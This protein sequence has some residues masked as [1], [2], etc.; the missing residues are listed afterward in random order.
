MRIV[1]LGTGAADHHWNKIGSPGVRGSASTLIDE[2][3]LVD[4]GKTGVS[5]LTRA[6]I[7]PGQI[8]DLLITHSHIDHFD[9]GQIQQ[10]IESRSSNQKP[11]NIWGST[12]RI[13]ALEKEITLEGKFVPHIIKAADIFQIKLCQVT[14]LPANHPLGDPQEQA[15]NFLFHTP[16]GNILYALDGAW[17]L[18]QARDLIGK[19]PLHMIFWD[20]TMSK[21]GDWRIFEHNDLE[22][23]G[24]MMQSLKKSGC[25]IDQTICVLS[26]I[27]RTLWP[28]DLNE[29][30]K[31]AKDRGWVLAAD[32]MSFELK[33]N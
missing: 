5:N 20:A 29:A 19:T 16:H 11:L 6:N 15:F 28:A 33:I 8:T 30:E 7:Q 23:I 1:T 9:L 2:H 3:I 31:L 26:H 14:V 10:L 12:Q 27:A 13:N 32:G 17:M 21:A 22:M 24:L 4:C 18:K 25:V